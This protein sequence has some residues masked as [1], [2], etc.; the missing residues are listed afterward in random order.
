MLISTSVAEE[1][2]D[3][4]ECNIVIRYGLMTNEIAM[5]QARGRARAPDSTYSVL[6]KADSKEV[7][8]EKLNETLE[9]LMNQAIASVQQM[10]EQEYHLKIGKLQ[11]ETVISR[12]IRDAGREQ[13][14]QLHDPGSVIFY[15]I[16]CHT[17]ICHGSDLRKIENMHHVNINPNFRLYYRTSV[18]HVTIPR[19]FKD[20]KPGSSISCS[21]CGQPWGMEMIYREIILPMLSIKNFVVESPG[22]KRT[23][24]QWSKI[25]FDVK[26]FNYIDY[27]DSNSLLD[28]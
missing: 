10:S 5:M 27:C 25:T 14:A 19:Q 26:E 17:A 8:R 16:G 21:K 1:G 28:I 7:A 2:L 3:I 6:A 13:L 12:R 18:G 20:W 23:Y 24:K 11:R 4:P 9:S 22:D 15:C